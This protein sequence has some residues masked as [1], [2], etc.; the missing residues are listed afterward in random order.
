M[1]ATS[2]LS[3]AFLD[4]LLTWVRT[5]SP[6]HDR[7]GVNLMM[8]LVQAAV[9]DLPVAVERIAGEQGLGDV[10]ILRTGPERDEPATLVMS[11]LD[12]VH[13]VGTLQHDLPVTVEGDR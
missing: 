4:D 12:T 8:D 9:A 10:L 1:N 5:E 11:H 7:A 6:T 13:P 3:P 2:P